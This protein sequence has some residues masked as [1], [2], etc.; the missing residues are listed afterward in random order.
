M[1]QA[2]NVQALADLLKLTHRGYFIPPR[3]EKSSVEGARMSNEFVNL[4]K[5]ALHHYLN[6]LAG[7]PVI[8]ESEVCNH[9]SHQHV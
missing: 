6:Q 9:P 3:P 8:R 2:G 7:H 1:G 5:D 4:R